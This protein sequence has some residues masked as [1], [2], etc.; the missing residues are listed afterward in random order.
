[1]PSDAFRGAQPL[2]TAAM[3]KTPGPKGAD[4]NAQGLEPRGRGARFHRE[5]LKRYDFN[6]DELELVLEASRQ[7][8]LC[9]RLHPAVVE[10][11][12]ARDLLRKLLNQLAM[13][14]EDAGQDRSVSARSRRAQQAAETRWNLHGRKAAP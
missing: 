13:P 4:V 7:L 6:P 1:M 11:R 8:D 10:L 14:D 5:A 12:Q 3:L 2:W 9:E